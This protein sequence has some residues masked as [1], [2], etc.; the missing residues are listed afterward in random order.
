[1]TRQLMDAQRAE[2][3][4]WAQALESGKYAQAT[5]KLRVVVNDEPSFCC[6]GVYADICG[7]R[8]RIVT[9]EP[10]ISGEDVQ[11]HGGS[12]LKGK[13]FKNLTGIDDVG[14]EHLTYLNDTT[15]HQFGDIARVL[16]EYARS[17]EWKKPEE[18]TQ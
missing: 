12:Y 11:A 6:L 8:W 14:Q 1:M 10:V 3:E 18:I 2:I 16:R 4:R 5:G 17:G 15:R 9:Q 13:W 7:A